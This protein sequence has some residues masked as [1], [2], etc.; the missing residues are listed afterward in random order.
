MDNIVFYKNR[1]VFRAIPKNASTYFKSKVLDM[2]AA[3]LTSDVYEIYRKCNVSA[4]VVVVRDPLSRFYSAI[5]EDTKTKTIVEKYELTNRSYEEKVATYIELLYNNFYS[6][7]LT[8]KESFNE[9]SWGK[10]GY[11]HMRPQVHW[12]YDSKGNSIKH[13]VTNYFNVEDMFLHKD[14]SKINEF[15]TA[16]SLNL[17]DSDR[18]NCNLFKSCELVDSIVGSYGITTDELVNKVYKDDFDLL[19]ISDGRNSNN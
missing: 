2:N 14:Y 16:H 15:L 12:L 6:K 8:A 9:W 18:Y 4:F 7:E 19:N 17:F 11:C 13:L 1:V 10:F 5:A 3:Y